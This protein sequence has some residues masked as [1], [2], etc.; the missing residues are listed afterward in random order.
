MIKIDFISIFPGLIQPYMEGSIMKR[1][2]EAR[3]ADFGYTDIRQFT[4]DKHRRVDD[5]PYGGGAGM[6]MQVEPIHRAVNAV[7]DEK[8][9]RRRIILLSAKGK[10]FT[11]RDAERLCAYEHLIFICGR[12]E[13]VD[14]RVAMHI[15]NEELSIGDFI[16]TGGELG[17]LV[18]ADSIVRLLPGVLGNEQSAICESHSKD[19]YREHPHYT[20]PDVYNGWTVPNVLISGN[21]AKI[22]QWRTEQAKTIYHD[23]EEEQGDKPAQ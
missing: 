7:I 6:I 8:K 17:A 14:E 2:R 11:Q 10:R 13:G 16:L 19:G 1:A 21:H 22:E 20:K 12:Y 18:I 4:V 9:D 15:A 5:T 23:H 3:A